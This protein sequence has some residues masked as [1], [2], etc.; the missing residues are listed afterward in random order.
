MHEDASP[1]AWALSDPVTSRT[2]VGRK[3]GGITYSKGASVIRMTAAFLGLEVLVQGLSSYLAALAYGNSVEEELFLHLEAAGRQ[4][5]SW[6]QQGVHS[7]QHTMNTWTNQVTAGL[8]C[9]PVIG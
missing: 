7:F 3:F 4:A 9:I 1:L 2:D 8:H 5:G 6:P